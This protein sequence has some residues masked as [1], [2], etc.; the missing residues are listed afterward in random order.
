MIVCMTTQ[1]KRANRWINIR[2]FKIY[3]RFGS[4]NCRCKHKQ[5]KEEQ[6]DDVPE[7]ILQIRSGHCHLLQDHKHRLFGEPSDM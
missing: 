7:T 1:I 3:R 2:V 6:M 5:N 4:G